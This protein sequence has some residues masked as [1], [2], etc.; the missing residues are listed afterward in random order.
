[1]IYFYILLF[2]FIL[3]LVFPLK[4]HLY[5]SENKIKI[6]LF[7]FNLLDDSF[8]NILKEVIDVSKNGIDNYIVSNADLEYFKILK[9]LKIR[10]LKISIGK[11]YF[12]YDKNALIYGTFLSFYSLIKNINNIE[13]YYNE[14]GAYLFKINGIFTSNLGKILLKYFKLRSEKNKYERTSN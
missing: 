4:L 3:I 10:A 6:D 2:I 7:S 11:P 5:I 14:K 1:M 9:K 12:E 8:D 13:I